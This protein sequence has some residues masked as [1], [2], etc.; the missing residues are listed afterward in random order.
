[1]RPLT[2]AMTIASLSTFLPPLWAAENAVTSQ[3]ETPSGKGLAA[4]KKAAEAKKYLFVFFYKQADSQ[5]EKLRGVFDAAMPKLA[6]KAQAV[7][8]NIADPEEKGIV[9]KLDVSKAP[10][11]LVVTLAPNGAVTGGFPRGF[12]EARLQNAFVSPGMA[13]C[14]KNLQ[15]NKLVLVCVQG[16]KTKHNGEAMQGAR[17]FMSD[18]QYGEVTRMVSLDPRDPEEANTLKHFQVD[19]KTREAVTVLLAPPGRI[20]T[21]F[22]GPTNKEQFVA[23]L[24][25]MTCKPG[26]GCCGK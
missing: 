8:V 7:A 23:A 19:P 6:D 16:K 15:E 12:D 26:S 1:M 20:V 17:A 14:L 21:R 9:E 18:P 11:P 13:D 4:I 24:T 2:L 10:M 25:K 3:P 5:T 22:S